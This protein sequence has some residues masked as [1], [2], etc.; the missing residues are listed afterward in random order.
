VSHQR[1]RVAWCI[2]SFDIGGS[3]LNAIRT[4]ELFEPTGIELRVF[5]FQSDGPLK[6]RYQNLGVPLVHM[7][8]KGL[9]S[10]GAVQQ[11][12]RFASEIRRWQ[13]HIV[14]CHDVYTN[15]FFGLSAR[16]LTHASIIT[17]RRWGNYWPRKGLS[18]LNAWSSRLSH[19]VLANSEAVARM[20]VDQDS[21]LPPKVVVVPN[22]LDDAAWSDFTDNEKLEFRSKL[23]IPH[24][25]FVVGSVSRVEPVKRLDVLIH[26]LGKLP[27]HVHGVIVGDGSDLPRLRQLAESTGVLERT[28]F[29]GQILSS[30]NTHFHFDM[31][32]VCSESEGF[33]NSLIEAMGAGRAVVATPVG[34]VLDVVENGKT[35]ILVPVGDSDALAAAIAYIYSAPP[36]VHAMAASG[37]ELISRH[38]RRSAVLAQLQHLYASLAKR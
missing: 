17:S 29:A 32:A 3:E 21:V 12:L 7:P 20:V 8:L 16:A 23:G 5:H 26:A 27:D 38:H 28:H 19:R 1:I 37:R 24:D 35:G 14:H 36:A 33:P 30:R 13:A 10:L 2:D 34:G 4:A 31:S 11:A 18:T 6:A 22:F 9:V 15:V 25:A